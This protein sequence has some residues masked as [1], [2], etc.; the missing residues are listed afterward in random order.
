M[1]GTLLFIIYNKFVQ[2]SYLI[3]SAILTCLN[4]H[5]VRSWYLVQSTSTFTCSRNKKVRMKRWCS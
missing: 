1:K 5:Q 2:Q 3:S 4:S